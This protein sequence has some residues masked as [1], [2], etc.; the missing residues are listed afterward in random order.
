[1]KCKI[2]GLESNDLNEICYYD[3]NGEP[4]CTEQD[5]ERNLFNP[6]ALTYELCNECAEAFNF[7]KGE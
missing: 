4:H 2:C 7:N 3:I 5:I 1:M 6:D